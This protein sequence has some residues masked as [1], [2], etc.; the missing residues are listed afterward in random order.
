[1]SNRRGID[2]GKHLSNL[3]GE[4]RVVLF[5]SALGGE[6]GEMSF[7]NQARFKHLPGLKT[8]ERT[9]ET[10]VRLAEFSGPSATKVPTPCRTFMMP[11]VAIYPIP[12]R[13]LARLI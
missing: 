9:H 13:R 3:F 11:I 2:G 5:P 1:M 10:Q 7:Q 6:C 8:V 12:A 4:R